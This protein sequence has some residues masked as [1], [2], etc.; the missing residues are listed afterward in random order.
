LKA[1]QDAMKTQKG[2]WHNWKKKEGRY[3]GNQ[4]SKR[5]HRF[6]CPNAK[7]IKRKNR[8]PFF[9]K[10]DAFHAGYAPAKK[11]IKEFWSY[12]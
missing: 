12:E 1:Q 2:L 5:F 7:N 11:C 6:E 3:I 9:T 10:W 4:N 8:T